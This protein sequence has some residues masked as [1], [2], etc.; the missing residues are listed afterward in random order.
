MLMAILSDIPGDRLALEAAVADL[1]ADGI[2]RGGMAE[3]RFLS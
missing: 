2:L 3:M 1:G